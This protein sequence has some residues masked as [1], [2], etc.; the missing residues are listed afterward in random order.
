MWH[1]SIQHMQMIELSQ[2]GIL[3][4]TSLGVTLAFI[5]N[6]FIKNSFAAIGDRFYPD[7]TTLSYFIYACILT[8]VVVS[9]I[10]VL[11]DSNT[12]N[13]EPLVKEVERPPIAKKNGWRR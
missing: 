3:I 12:M 13:N 7:N 5:W 4:V 11:S 9:I 10:A 1:M 2:L 6:E 8:V